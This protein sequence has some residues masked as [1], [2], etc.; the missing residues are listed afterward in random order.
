LQKMQANHETTDPLPAVD[1]SLAMPRRWAGRMGIRSGETRS[2]LTA[3]LLFFTLLTAIM[4]LRP[5]RD[6][7]GLARGIENVRQLFLVTVTAT[8]LVASLFGR[9]VSRTRRHR[10]LAVS[11]RSCAVILI[12]FL[13]G[14]ALLPEGVRG[15]IGSVYYV[16]HSVFNLFVVS[17]F[18]AFMADHFGLA[19]SKRLFPA[20]A[21][22]GSLGA[23]VGSLVSWQLAEQFGVLWLFAAAAGLLELAV[24]V[25]AWFARTRSA[26]HGHLGQLRPLGGASLAGL[27]AVVQSP[28]IRNIALFVALIG[29]VSTFLY[30]TS[31]RLVASTG[32][33]TPQQAA[34]FAQINLWTQAATLLAQAFVAA[35]IMRWAGVGSALAV[36]PALAVGGF[37]A[38][39]LLPTLAT[40]TVVN[41]LYQ[42]AQQ[43]ITGPARE[44][45]FTV[46]Q[47]QEKYKAK[48]FVDTFGY[49]AG[50]ASAALLER[51]LAG[52][53]SGV[54]PVASAVFGLA[55]LWLA[56][57]V[58]LGRT[59]NRLAETNKLTD[60]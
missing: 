22:G 20:I 15:W 24:W 16:F 48:P 34:L 32:R 2:V 10:L 49:R 9:V 44:T 13:G 51:P 17:L 57:S 3:G 30:F 19:E 28:Y 43:G 46:L 37:G 25:A 58:F 1:Q 54:L 11:F 41:A 35:R 50:D 36:L 7:L 47:P 56:L 52:L 38:L 42:A 21:I 27:K 14:M 26:A 18:W 40:F 4:I 55:V 39:A 8:L 33:S 6:A 29:I 31:L 5:V 59:Q 12:C 60:P 53:S 45:L 23:I